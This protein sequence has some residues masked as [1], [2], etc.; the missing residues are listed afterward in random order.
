[1]SKGVRDCQKFGKHC[2]IHINKLMSDSFLIRHS[3]HT[4]MALLRLNPVVCVVLIDDQVFI[5]VVG[6]L[7]IADYTAWD[8]QTP[9]N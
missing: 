4:V 2:T 5:S 9:Q 7:E 1:M 8:S 3:P 6:R